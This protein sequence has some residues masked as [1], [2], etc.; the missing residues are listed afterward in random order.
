LLLL[1]WAAFIGYTAEKLILG[2]PAT[3]VRYY[4]SVF[5][6][7]TDIGHIPVKGN[8]GSF[9]GPFLAAQLIYLS[10][11]L[12]LVFFE[13]RERKRTTGSAR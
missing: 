2:G 9:W 1:Y 13:W 12:A 3:L 4:R 7:Q 11:T 6:M 5:Y 8:G 10:I